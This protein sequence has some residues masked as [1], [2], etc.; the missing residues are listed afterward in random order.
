MNQHVW[1]Y[2]ARASGV[3]TWA[4]VT[5]SVVLGLWLSLRLTKKYPRPAWTL[6]LHRFLGALAVVF[7]GVHLAG[8]VADSYVHFGARELFVPFA[9]TWHP[10]AVALGILGLYL[11]L[12]IEVTSLAMRA[13]PRKLWRT[14]HLTSYPL[15]VVATI[16]MFAAGTDA[17]RP[18]LQWL[19]L[20]GVA[21]VG[22]L[23][24]ARLLAT[25]S[26]PRRSARPVAGSTRRVAGTKRARAQPTVTRAGRAAPAR[27][28]PAA[29]VTTRR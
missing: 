7:T 17:S 24:C 6:D 9:S 19:G 1:W 12:A 8:L 16:H 11:L 25:T 4:L 27:T 26:S 14:V 22:F 29:A 18:S 3:V 10:D 2:L 21:A 5:A 20:G 15:F 23:T 13:I 28:R